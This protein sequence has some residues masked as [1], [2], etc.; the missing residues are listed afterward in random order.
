MPQDAA[1]AAYL[2][3]RYRDYLILLARSNLD[4]RLRGQVDLSDVVQ[5]TLLKAHAKRG[6]FRG[7]TE[8]QWLA[9]LRAILANDLAE[10]ARKRGRSPRALSIEASL[11]DSAERL[12]TFL[13][14]DQSSPSQRAM[15]VE[16]LASLVEALAS[17]PQDQRAALEFQHFEGLTVAQVAE[18]MGRSLASVTNL[19]YRAT[20]TLRRQMG[21]EL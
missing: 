16:R 7:T 14:A 18:R 12:A 13:A 10:A 2:L 5:Q 17:L 4:S 21:E 6:Q 3:E 1:G 11:E 20:K 15:K 8:G 19:I 9:W